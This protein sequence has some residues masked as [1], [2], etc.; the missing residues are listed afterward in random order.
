[1]WVWYV[2]LGLLIFGGI[3]K[4]LFGSESKI[5]GNAGEI[6]IE[7]ELR[8]V[9][10]KCRIFRSVYVDIPSGKTEVDIVAVDKSGIYVIESKNYSGKI[11]G[12][13]ASKYWRYYHVGGSQYTFY[14]PIWQN[15]THVNAIKYQLRIKQSQVVSYVVFGKKS[16]LRKIKGNTDVRVIGVQAIGEA[17]KRDIKGRGRVFT[18]KELKELEKW[19][20]GSTRVSVFTKISHIISVKM[21]QAA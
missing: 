17:M 18:D 13:T 12:D 8:K 1:M 11:E 10:P 21:K 16:E 19:F 9:I 7:R 2:I 4:E 15:R 20:K 14:N 3:Y 6:E 5:I